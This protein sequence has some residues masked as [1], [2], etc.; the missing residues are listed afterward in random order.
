MITGFIAASFG[1]ILLF[2]F[3]LTGGLRFRRSSIHVHWHDT[4]LVISYFQFAVFVCLW[5]GMFFY[6]SASLLT[7]FNEE[8]FY[9]PLFII[10]VT[11]TVIVI[12]LFR[13][14]R[15]G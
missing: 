8:L 2:L 4:Y 15:R 10:V 13:L 7:N 9:I 1:I 12:R 6:L 11:G 5:V 14:T 3:C